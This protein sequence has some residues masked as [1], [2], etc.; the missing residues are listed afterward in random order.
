MQHQALIVPVIAER[1]KECT[2]CTLSSILP[3]FFHAPS[4]QPSRAIVNQ[5]NMADKEKMENDSFLKS[6][7]KYPS[8]HEQLFAFTLYL[9]FNNK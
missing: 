8:G 4:N 2:K 1:F 6:I 9:A 5:S 3:P 7:C